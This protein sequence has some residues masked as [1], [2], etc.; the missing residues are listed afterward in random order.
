[1]QG[2]SSTEQNCL[3]GI[4]ANNNM[5]LYHINVFII[6]NSRISLKIVQMRCTNDQVINCDTTVIVYD[7]SEIIIIMRGV[8]FQLFC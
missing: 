3:K 6:I 7:L 5:F 8:N 4:E 2:E 1:M